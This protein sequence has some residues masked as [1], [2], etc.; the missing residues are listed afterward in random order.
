MN[1]SSDQQVLWQH[2]FFKLNAT[3]VT[4]WAMMMAMA[5]G[6]K[7]ITRRLAAEG[8]ISRWQGALEIIV[9]AIEKQ[10]GEGGLNQPQKS[11]ASLGP[12][13]LFAAT[14]SLCTVIPGYRPPTGSLSTTAVLAL[15]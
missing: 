8:T 14:S 11:L 13:F 15:G 4:T 1:L 10:I 2:G 6:A 7:L 5:L 3:V 12:L 9:T